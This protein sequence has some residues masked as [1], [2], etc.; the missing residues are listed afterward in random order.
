MTVIGGGDQKLFSALFGEELIDDFKADGG[1]KEPQDLLLPITFMDMRNVITNVITYTPIRSEWEKHCRIIGALEEYYADSGKITGPP[2]VLWYDPAAKNI[3]STPF[4]IFFTNK[5]KSFLTAPPYNFKDSEI[6]ETEYFIL[7]LSSFFRGNYDGG[8]NYTYEYKK[9]ERKFKSLVRNLRKAYE[10]YYDE[11]TRIRITSDEAIL[12]AAL[13]L[14]FIGKSDVKDGYLRALLRECGQTEPGRA[15]PIRNS[16]F[17]SGVA[18]VLQKNP[19][20]TADET[21]ATAAG[22]FL[23]EDGEPIPGIMEQS[24]FII[25]KQSDSVYTYLKDQFSYFIDRVPFGSWDKDQWET[26]PLVPA[27]LA[28][29]SGEE[30]YLSETDIKDMIRLTI[31]LEDK[32][33]DY[34]ASKHTGDSLWVA[35][36][37]ELVRLHYVFIKLYLANVF[38]S[39]EKLEIKNTIEYFILSELTLYG[40]MFGEEIDEFKKILE[41]TIGEYFELFER[42]TLGDKKALKDRDIPDLINKLSYQSFSTLDN[43]KQDALL[44]GVDTY[45]KT[46]YSLLRCVEIGWPALFILSD[47]SHKALDESLDKVWR[48]SKGKLYDVNLSYYNER[49]DL[50]GVSLPD[51]QGG[52]A[53]KPGLIPL[54]IEEAQ[55]NPCV[56]VYLVF[57]NVHAVMDSLRVELFPLLWEKA[58]FIA[59]LQKYYVL[60]ENLHIIFTMEEEGLIKDEAYLD[61]VLR[62]RVGNVSRQDML[63][64]LMN[65]YGIEKNAA[66]LLSENYES[67]SGKKWLQEDMLFSPQDYINI[68]IYAKNRG[69]SIDVLR[70]ELYRYFI[71]RFRYEKDRNSFREAFTQEFGKIG[72]SY[73]KA[74][75][76]ITADEAIV[77]GIRVKICPELSEFKRTNPGKSFEEAVLALYGYSLRSSDKKTFAQLVRALVLRES[78]TSRFFINQG[79]SGE[80]KTRSLEVFRKILM[81]NNLSY[82]VHKHTTR[83]EYRGG[84]FPSRD[85]VIQVKDS[86]PFT[87]A[88]AAGGFLINW[89]EANTSYKA[90][91]P[92]WLSPLALGQTSWLHT[93]IPGTM[94]EMHYPNSEDNIYALDINPDDFRARYKIPAQIR[95]FSIPIWSGYDYSSQDEDYL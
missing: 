38:I 18:A 24:R 80:G 10:G 44:W 95:R 85:G 6:E 79:A 54:V 59:E 42:L 36:F 21:S 90:A 75:I 53:F 89:S 9:W 29:L 73:D 17:L 41:E 77:D 3:R 55:G 22:R 31:D 82:T 4:L 65:R 13:A 92:T 45:Q 12:I 81:I 1:E 23:N 32:L 93:D 15:P 39:R 61:R 69:A 25:N 57:R 49:P 20:L 74:K 16:N 30:F 52:Y 48:E 68:G 94:E 84:M 43:D 7:R 56:P 47:K 34:I 51:K 78:S 91:L 5:E 62:Q 60:P 50:I 88:V 19:A 72:S 35:S 87:E 58:I 11:E 37:R 46:Y 86:T 76:E 26:H 40:G 14:S 67:L 71:L 63:N 64:L 33:R 83:E 8:S 70:E 27:L 2:V 28:Y 66:E